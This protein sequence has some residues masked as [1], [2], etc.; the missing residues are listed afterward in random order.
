M[1]FRIWYDDGTVYTGDDPLKVSKRAGVQI[2]A[3]E[4]PE[5][6]NGRYLCHQTPYYIWLEG[7]GWC[8]ADTAG[9]WDYL[10]RPGLFPRHVLIGRTM[11]STEA[12][13]AMLDRAIEEGVD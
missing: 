12:F 7:G 13:N 8:A 10:L 11:S 6:T 1:R 5:A 2:I 3:Q 4:H 9:F